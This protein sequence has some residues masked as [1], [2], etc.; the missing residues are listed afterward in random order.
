MEGKVIIVLA[1]SM[2]LLAE[3]GQDLTQEYR[4]RQPGPDPEARLRDKE[5]CIPRYDLIPDR[6]HPV[7][8]RSQRGKG[9]RSW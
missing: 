9:R 4:C 5:P 3:H 1:A 8:P 6:T 2:G 7:S